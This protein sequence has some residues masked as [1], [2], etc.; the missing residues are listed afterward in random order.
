[1]TLTLKLA[2]R[3]GSRDGIA[4]GE[5]TIRD[6]RG[7]VRLRGNVRGSVQDLIVVEGR[8]SGRLFDPDARLLTSISLLLI[9][10]YT[11]VTGQF[12]FSPAPRSAAVNG[13]LPRCPARA[14][15]RP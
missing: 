15:A 13:R 3:P 7:R 10:Q 6:K 8:L 2:I 9:P 4:T 11:F 1:M 12:G 5:L 14:G